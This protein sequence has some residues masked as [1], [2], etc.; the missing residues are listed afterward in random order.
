MPIPEQRIATVAEPVDTFRRPSSSNAALNLAQ[1]LRELNPNI[2]A[3]LEPINEE[4]IR[5]QH[6]EGRKAAI[7]H[8]RDWRDAVQRND[9]RLGHN[10]WFRRAYRTQ[11][12]RQAGQELYQEAVAEYANWEGRDSDNP[13]AFRDWIGGFIRDRT[14]TIQ[15]HDLIAGLLPELNTMQNNL[16]IMH[17]SYTA[18][19]V[20]RE[21]ADAM[22]NAVVSALHRARSGPLNLVTGLR[23]GDL[24][25]DQMQDE[26][27]TLRDQFFGAGV[28]RSRFDEVFTQSVLDESV[29]SLDETMLSILEQPRRDGTPPIA[30]KAGMQDRINAARAQIETRAAS[31]AIAESRLAAAQRAEQ[32][33]N[34]FQLYAMELLEGGQVSPET[35]QQI[36][37][38]GATGV[39]NVR[40]FRELA[41][42]WREGVAAI[43][44]TGFPQTNDDLPPELIRAVYDRG[45][46]GAVVRAFNDGTITDRDLFSSL[47]RAAVSR[48]EG[49]ESQDISRTNLRIR[50]EGE[51]RSAVGRALL[52]TFNDRVGEPARAQ[53][54]LNSVLDEYRPHRARLV[55]SFAARTGVSPSVAASQIDQDVAAFINRTITAADF[56]AEYGEGAQA[57]LVPFN[58]IR[59][60]PR[61]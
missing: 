34:A 55:D 45:D 48:R 40:E 12:G 44:N 22:N 28:T 50:V 3:F 54:E 14:A 58:Y 53:Q 20:E 26:Y 27:E 36:A 2:Q 37:L 43:D 7:E 41:T 33:Q 9:R 56:D 13:A 8:A 19:R 38:L 10:P 59:V 5:G 57:A 39:I 35:Q 4:W 11:M 42:A 1:S 60:P 51:E 32:A 24:S 23:A 49:E 25:V 21:G 46:V 30:R 47:T 15:N 6:E 31:S 61:Q 17:A 52:R 16:N 29:N 18:T